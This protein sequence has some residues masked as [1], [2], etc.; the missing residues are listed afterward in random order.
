M[1][2][3]GVSNPEGGGS[4]GAKFLMGRKKRRQQ[5]RVRPS[6]PVED[7]KV[8][9]WDLDERVTGAALPVLQLYRWSDLVRL[10]DKVA[11]LLREGVGDSSPGAAGGESNPPNHVV[12]E[13]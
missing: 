7:G 4:T 2:P 10:S 5:A 12:G 3:G 1:L 13:G 11:P 8:I 6:R 9:E